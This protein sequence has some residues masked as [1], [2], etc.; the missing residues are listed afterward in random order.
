MQ[1]GGPPANVIR[2]GSV[3]VIP[4]TRIV[5]RSREE[6]D[7]AGGDETCGSCLIT[8]RHNERDP[9]LAPKVSPR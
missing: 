5:V 9:L 1:T 7:L 2:I 3:T 4:G 6:G 8:T